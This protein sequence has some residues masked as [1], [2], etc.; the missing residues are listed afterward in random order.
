M[1]DADFQDPPRRDGGD[2][3]PL[4][5]KDPI[6]HLDERNEEIFM[7]YVGILF[8]IDEQGCIW[9]IAQQCR[10]KITPVLKRRAEY[11]RKDGYLRVRMTL[12]GIRIRVSAHRLVYRY[13]HGPIPKC[14]I[15]N[16]KHPELGR[17]CNHPQNLEPLSQSDN[18]KHG[19]R[20]K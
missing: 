16:H 15:I 2:L 11:P 20:W 14:A 12:N 4:A 13:F 10:G 3:A 5:D 18:I 6:P 17:F 9:R 8:E 19:R 1:G 7:R